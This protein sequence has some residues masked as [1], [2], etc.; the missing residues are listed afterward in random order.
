M[1]AALYEKSKQIAM[2]ESLKAL[3][4]HSLRHELRNWLMSK[5]L[6]PNQRFVGRVNNHVI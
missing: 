1:L 5:R 4:R 3:Q 6:R 2:T